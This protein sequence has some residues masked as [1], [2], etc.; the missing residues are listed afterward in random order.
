MKKKSFLILSMLMSILFVS[1]GFI[2][3]Y[4][5]YVYIYDCEHGSL[6]VQCLSENKKGSDF[7]VT[8][9]PEDGYKLDV[10]HL[11]I[12]NNPKETD[13][14]YIEPEKERITSE[15]KNENQFQFYAKKSLNITV[16]AYFTKK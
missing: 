5:T 9:Y 3:R 16:Y 6:E 4:N 7:L 10:N 14:Y 12:Y 11:F 2:P 1:C 13:E 8:A 15:K